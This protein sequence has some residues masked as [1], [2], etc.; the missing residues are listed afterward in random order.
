[1]KKLARKMISSRKIQEEEK[2]KK[3][4][5]RALE[6]KSQGKKIRSLGE[7]FSDFIFFLTVLLDAVLHPL[8]PIMICFK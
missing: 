2:A 4:E 1:M 5:I 7:I 8:D 3:A 6:E